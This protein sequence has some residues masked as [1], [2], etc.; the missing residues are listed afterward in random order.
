MLEHVR[1]H[2]EQLR[3]NITKSF[4]TSGGADGSNGVEKSEAK[5]EVKKAEGEGEDKDKVEKGTEGQGGVITPETEEFDKEKDKTKLKDIDLTKAEDEG[6]NNSSFTARQ[7][8]TK[9]QPFLT[10]TS[11][12]ALD[13]QKARVASVYGT[14][15]KGKKGEGSRGG[16]VIGHT[17]SGKTIYDHAGHEGHKNFTPSDHKDAAAIHKKK[18]LDS[19]SQGM[20]AHEKEHKAH[21]AAGEKKAKDRKDTLHKKLDEKFPDDAKSWKNAGGE[22]ASM[23]THLAETHNDTPSDGSFTK[24]PYKE[25]EGRSASPS[26]HNFRHKKGVKELYDKVGEH[27]K[28]TFHEHYDSVIGDTK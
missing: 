8:L 21:T 10:L 18:G 5:E 25:H 1:K 14:I 3:S 20:A 24:E 2:Q 19:F 9:S 26:E 7:N 12:F 16:K 17:S 11:G 27:G 22:L 15:E 28:D 4:M 13:A 6:S 23:H